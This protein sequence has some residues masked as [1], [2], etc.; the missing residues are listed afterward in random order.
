ML[1]D[2]DGMMEMTVKMAGAMQPM[3]MM[4]VKTQVMVM[5]VLVTEMTPIQSPPHIHILTYTGGPNHLHR[6]GSTCWTEPKAPGA[7]L[8]SPQ[9]STMPDCLGDLDQVIYPISVSSGGYTGPFLISLCGDEIS[10]IM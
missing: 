2:P 9:K 3:E 8:V 1:T 4:V 7:K 6:V 10:Y 5:I